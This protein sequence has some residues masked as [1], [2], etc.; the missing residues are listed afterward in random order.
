MSTRR[1]G[2]SAPHRILQAGDQALVVEFGDTIDA[3]LN[4][5]VQ[6]LDHRVAEAAI[7]GVI[8]CVPTY[9][10]LMIVY[11]PSRIAAAVLR[12][13]IEK[14]VPKSAA[15]EAPARRWTLPVAY[16]GAH[17]LD[18]EDVARAHG[19]TTD[20]VIALH[21]GADYRVYMI[22]FS[23]GLAYLGGLPERLHTPRRTSPRL[24]VPASSVSIGGIQAAV[25]SV[26]IPSG[27]H[28]LG[29]TPERMFDLRRAQPFLLGAGD[30]VR[31]RPISPAEYDRLAALA[32]RGEVV[33][34]CEAA[35]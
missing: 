33:A 10:S 3:D 7:E 19:L 18:L 9:R 13:R 1:R 4:R 8:E 24:R 6:A 12:R 34:E 11:D 31:F 23:P 15:A 30:R 5:L 21:S 28:L 32:E 16:G 22:G 14:Q 27:W 2:A 35:A 25:F 29:R 20:E 26:E 17:G